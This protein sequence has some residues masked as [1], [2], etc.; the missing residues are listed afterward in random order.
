MFYYILEVVKKKSC[1]EKFVP[2]PDIFV[3]FA[4]VVCLLFKLKL[5]TK[6]NV[7]VVLFILFIVV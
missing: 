7:K 4:I 2:V 5:I 1:V 3:L 6:P